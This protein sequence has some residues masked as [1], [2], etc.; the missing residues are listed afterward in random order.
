MSTIS[1]FLSFCAYSYLSVFLSV[2]V[3]I[4]HSFCLCIYISITLSVCAYTCLSFFL[5]VDTRIYDSFCLCISKSI[6][7]SVCWY[8]YL[9]L[10]LSVHL[11]IYNS[12]YLCI[13]ITLSKCSYTSPSL[14]LSLHKRIY[15][16]FYLALYPS[17]IPLIVH[18][19]IYLWVLISIGL[20]PHDWINST[21]T[22]AAATTE[23]IVHQ[24]LGFIFGP[25]YSIWGD[26][27]HLIPLPSGRY[28]TRGNEFRSIFGAHT[29]ELNRCYFY[30]SLSF[31]CVCVFKPHFDRHNHWKKSSW[32]LGGRIMDDAI[33]Q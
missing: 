2:H 16:Y 1:F 22:T 24:H 29:K 12:F 33:A 21:K 4:Y 6:S 18:K 14:N 26:V 28:Y 10:F 19:S 32:K 17:V 27:N 11:Y 23:S 5:S 15:L 8:T 9:W 7:L 13:S 25:N 30:L 31:A 3:D 20:S